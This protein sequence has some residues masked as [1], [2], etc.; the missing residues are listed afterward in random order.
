MEL[1]VAGGDDEK[2]SSDIFDLT[3]MTFRPGPVFSQG[4]T[5]AASVQYGD[6]FLIVG[7]ID[8]RYLMLDTW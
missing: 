2:Y 3:S 5:E 8:A 1:I 6:T 4:L 7:G